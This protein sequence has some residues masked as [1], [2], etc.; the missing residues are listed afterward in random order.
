MILVNGQPGGCILPTDRGLSYGDGV[1]R[2]LRVVAGEVRY[3]PQ[4]YDHLAADAARLGIAVPDRELLA[5]ELAV[6][7]GNALD[8]VSKILLTRGVGPRGYAPPV[9]PVVTRVVSF[10]NL[11]EWPRHWQTEGVAVHLCQLRLAHQPRLAGIKHLNRLE[12]VLA[13]AEWQ[14]PGIAEGILLDQDGWLVSGTMSNLLL[15]RDGA[16]LTPRLD[17][18]GV[19]GL[20]RDLLL[21]QAAQHGIPVREDRLLLE[22]LLE[23]DE[24]MLCNSVFGVW[25]VRHLES[26]DW[27]RGNRVDQLRGWLENP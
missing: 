19:A 21:T 2:T 25:Q 14:T 23:A 11:P 4:Q 13:R 7:R 6:A 16:L 26:R 20:T 3:W 5:G 18:C 24:V 22:D 12:Q 17:R 1:F 10:G 8:G 27:N 9:E 15:W